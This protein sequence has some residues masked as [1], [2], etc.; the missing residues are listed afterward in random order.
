MRK[1]ILTLLGC[2]L[3]VSPYAA[4]AESPTPTPPAARL[5]FSKTGQLSG[6][7]I[8]W[9][10]SIT[11]SG[12]KN[13]DSQTIQDILPAGVYWSVSSIA[14]LTCSVGPVITDTTRQVLECNTLSVPKAEFDNNLFAIVNG[15]AQVNVYG[16]AEKCGVYHNIAVRNSLDVVSASVDVPCPTPTATPTVP[17]TATPTQTPTM[18]VTATNTPI[19]VSP[20]STPSPTPTTKIVPL[21]PKTGNTTG[22]PETAYDVILIGS[23]FILT[24]LVIA[25]YT[26]RRNR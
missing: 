13:S 21:P 10:I 22:T 25:V 24:G 9:T 23:L 20:T 18:V 17:P 15:L 26:S 3:A 5:Q 14:G 1:I 8:T 11:N 4:L 19:P 6:N 16:Y 12:N 7:I 2:M